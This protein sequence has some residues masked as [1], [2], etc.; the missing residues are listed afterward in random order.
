MKQDMKELWYMI[1]TTA[2][3]YGAIRYILPLFVPFLFSYFFAKLLYAGVT[4]FY[5]KWK[6]S[7]KMTAILLPFLL[8]SG[9]GYGLFY[10][11]RI[12]LYQLQ[13][14]MVRFPIYEVILWKRMGEICNGCDAM[15]SMKQGSA[16]SF[17]I[18]IWEE[19]VSQWKEYVGSKMFLHT[20]PGIGKMAAV[21]WCVIIIVWG[22]LLI[23]KDMEELKIIYEE[24]YIGHHGS[25]IMKNLSGIGMAYGKAELMIFFVV[26]LISLSGFLVIGN[27]YAVLLALFVSV[28]DAFPVLGSGVVLLPLAF[29]QLFH[30]NWFGAAVLT[31]QYIACQLAREY[32][33]AKM[34]GNRMGIKPIFTIMA[35]YAGVQLFGIFGFILGPIALMIIKTVLQNQ[36]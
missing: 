29:I 9:V 25:H 12:V 33:E 18:T 13:R 15:F 1:G 21:L 5:K 22:M 20:I 11:I 2:A 36:Y 14:L 3:V 28:V 34:I 24:S 4:Y 26:F 19:N 7:K 8:L 10:F 16:M 32:I 27:S 31:T 17:F 30:G 23:V 6:I 35:M